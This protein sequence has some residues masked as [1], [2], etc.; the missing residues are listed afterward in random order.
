MLVLDLVTGINTLLASFLLM[1]HNII[2]GLN[3][4]NILLIE[5]AVQF[6]ISVAGKEEQIKY[7]T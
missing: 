2:Q 6:E 7:I 5:S 4:F 1:G 3:N